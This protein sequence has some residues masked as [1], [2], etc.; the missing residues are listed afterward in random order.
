MP[1]VADALIDIDYTMASTAT[2]VVGQS[3]TVR[4]RFYDAGNN[5]VDTYDR[6]RGFRQYQDGLGARL[7]RL[8]HRR[9]LRHD[10]GSAYRRAFTPVR[11]NLSTTGAA[12][13]SI[14]WKIDSGAWADLLCPRL[15]TRST[16]VA[17]SPTASTRSQHYGVAADTLITDGAVTFSEFGW[18]IDCLRPWTFSR[19]PSTTKWYGNAPIPWAATITD[20]TGSGVAPTPLVSY[21]DAA[22]HWRS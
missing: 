7:E 14:V 8:W 9:R 5:V 12:P 3:F 10:A 19:G 11:A 22:A 21:T 2:P 18:D 17:S 4:V 15:S 1:Y 20:D 16:S 13:H 6:N